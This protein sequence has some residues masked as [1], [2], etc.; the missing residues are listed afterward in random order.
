[1]CVCGWV[2]VCVCVCSVS[3]HL[4]P[5][6]AFAANVLDFSNSNKPICYCFPRHDGSIDA[7]FEGD[8]R[9]VGQVRRVGKGKCVCVC[10]CVRERE[11]VCE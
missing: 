9:F 5:S 3:F 2:C 6:Q 10:V 1:M 7:R 8:D 4:R 11:C